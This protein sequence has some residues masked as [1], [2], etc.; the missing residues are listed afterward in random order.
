MEFGMVADPASKQKLSPLPQQQSYLCTKL[1][2]TY[3][4]RSGAQRR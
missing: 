4:S 1:W 2:C 3:S